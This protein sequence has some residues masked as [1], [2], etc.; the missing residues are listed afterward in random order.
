MSERNGKYAFIPDGYQRNGFIQGTDFHPDMCFVYRPT[1][2]IER[3]VINGS[4]RIEYAKGTREGFAKSEK[5]GAEAL[6]AHLL[7]WDV[8]GPNVHEVELTAENVL[9]IEPH[10]FVRL[11]QIIMGES[12]SDE[13]EEQASVKNLPTG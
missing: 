10:L 13:L 7:S 11:Y 3:T 1:T 2:I 4:V 12:I 8:K 5:L 9:R 6:V